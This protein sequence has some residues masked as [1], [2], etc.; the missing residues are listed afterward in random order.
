[1]SSAFRCVVPRYP[2]H[3]RQ[4]GVRKGPIFYEDADCLVYICNIKYACVEHG[5]SIRSY[6]LMTN[7]VHLV[8]VPKDVDSIS[9]T[10]HDA[11][12]LYSGYFNGKYGFVSHVWQSGPDY[13]AMDEAYMWNAV[14]YVERNPVRAG[15]VVCAEDYLWS[16]AAAHCGLRDDI[17]LAEDF[18]PP[19]VIRDWSE[20]LRVD[21]REEE[22]KV[23]R[24]HLSTG[25][26]W[27]TPDFIHE[28]E[29]IT[30]QCLNQSPRGRPKKGI[31][32]QAP[33]LFDGAENRK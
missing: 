32:D 8:A 10:L 27:G 30:G 20:W 15:M 9:R 7:H 16:S 19:G 23:I 21:H 26:P 4:R 31:K 17:L 29:A 12:T 33:T 14:R 1:M 22:I 2:H 18:P 25:R 28:L 24:Q 5:V 3:I 6:A 13:S 11:H